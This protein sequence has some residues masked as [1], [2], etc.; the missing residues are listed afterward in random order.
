MPFRLLGD[1]LGKGRISSEKAFNFP[2]YVADKPYK[3]G[4]VV[5]DSTGRLYFAAADIVANPNE[6]YFFDDGPHWTATAHRLIG[7]AAYAVVIPEPTSLVLVA[8]GLLGLMTCSRPRDRMGTTR[9]A[10]HRRRESC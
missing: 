2:E 4:D 10:H 9:V 8:G 3:A 5:R 6:H 7:D 1:F